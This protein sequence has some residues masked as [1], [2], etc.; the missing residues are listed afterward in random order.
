[1]FLIDRCALAIGLF[2]LL[3]CATTALAADPAAT[4]TMPAAETD[5]LWVTEQ[6]AA[7][8]LATRVVAPGDDLPATLRRSSFGLIRR[9]AGSVS[10]LYADGFKRDAFTVTIDGERYTTACPNRMDTRVGQV[11]LLDVDLVELDRTGGALQAG[12]GGR[13][14]FQRRRPGDAMQW[15]GLVS[16]AFDHVK[17]REIA[18][19]A[20]M[21]RM[22]ASVRYRQG[23][24][25]T[26]AE[27]QGFTDLY[28]YAVEPTSEILELQLAHAYGS[29]DAV[30]GYESSTD[31][32]FPYLKM[33]ERENDH[34]QASASWRG[35]RLYVNRNEHVMDNALRTSRAMTDMRTDATNTMAGVTA[36]RWEAYVRNWDADNRIIPVANPAMAT[37]NRMLP[38]VWR[39]QAAAHH[40]FGDSS[41]VQVGLRLGV[42]HTRV[43]DDAQASRYDVLNPDAET[44]VWSVPFGA[45]ASHGL[46]LGPRWRL[47]LAAEVAADAPGIEEL[48][49]S[50]DRP[51]ANPTWIGNPELDDPRRATLRAELRRGG[52]RGEIFGTRA[53]NFAYP[54]RRM[55]G[56]QAYQSYEG[57]GALLAGVNVSWTS[58]YVDAGAVWNWGEATDDQRPLA[59]IQPLMLTLAARS[60]RL[61]PARGRLLYEHAGGQSRVDERLDERTTA[62]WDR[63]DLAV[64]V[65]LGSWNVT[66]ALDNAFNGRYTQHLSYLRNPFASGVPI[67]EPG[68]SVKLMGVFRLP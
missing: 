2:A 34:Y 47:G 9:G 36:A 35:H 30:V 56:E 46:D 6:P 22:R 29:G 45:T 67:V 20:E 19:S 42:A 16:G 40:E 15:R 64:D 52:F 54:V 18:L 11:N 28:G 59:E 21:N 58:E 12:L 48:F 24:P 13:V 26:D 66:L 4:D 3:A 62:S 57:I 1:M 27:G 60:P 51:G 53:W 41:R 31:V 39:Y 25:W 17:E 43:G 8:G 37:T 33:D 23:E 68:R 63:V 10:D 32:P 55:V 38:D 7:V 5:T 65:A 50:V 61:G 44:E 49:I 14:A